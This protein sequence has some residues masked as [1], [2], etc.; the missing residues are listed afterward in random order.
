MD[1]ELKKALDALKL[2]LEGLNAEQLKEI[3][4]AIPVGVWLDLH[5]MSWQRDKIAEITIPQ[6][7]EDVNHYKNI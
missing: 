6:L 1:A 4:L 3:I 7:I 2:K 5:T